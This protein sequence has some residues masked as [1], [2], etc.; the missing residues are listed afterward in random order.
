MSNREVKGPPPENESILRSRQ[1][2]LN[3]Y[4]KKDYKE[5]ENKA[6]H[7]VKKYKDD[8]IV[9]Q[10]LGVSQR[11]L[12]K[13]QLAIRSLQ[14][15]ESLLPNDIAILTSLSKT[16]HKQ[17]QKQEY[18]EVAKKLFHLNAIDEG[19]CVS[20]NRILYQMGN[21]KE[22]LKWCNNFIEVYP[23]N[24]ELYFHLSIALKNVGRLPEAIEKGRKGLELRLKHPTNVKPQPQK[25]KFN[26]AE[27]K[28]VLW[29][30][31]VDLKKQNIHA[32]PTA[33]TLLGLIREGDLLAGDKDIDLALLYE[34]IDDAVKILEANG[35]QEVKGSY[36]LIN[37]RQMYYPKYKL[38]IDLCGLVKEKESG[39]T[40]GGFWM[41]GIPKE[42]N[43]I[44]EFPA[45]K[46]NKAQSPAGEV[47]WPA[48]PEV[49]LESLY[50]DWRTPD[51]E[52]DTVICANNLRNFSYLVECYAIHRIMF[53]WGQGYLSKALKI[54]TSTLKHKPNNEL[55]QEIQRRFLDSLGRKA[56]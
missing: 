12:G 33:G 36:V 37:P 4:Q 34:E 29:Q 39:K 17:N 19:T 10:T 25:P 45:M 40:I 5:A 47:W 11:N 52:F 56:R 35:W 18:F 50:G 6:Q 9:W 3:H 38:T 46:L 1:L 13:T 49:W 14:K 15:A 54:V 30:V 55:Y 22:T 44:I 2:I 24:P 21:P 28:Q 53:H 26:S 41:P 48:E 23:A 31:L 43:R 27:N 7:H 20:A 32:F 16:L 51:N 42:W 8:A